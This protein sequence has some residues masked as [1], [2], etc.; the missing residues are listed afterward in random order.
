[1][2]RLCY[3]LLVDVLS[4]AVFFPQSGEAKQRD[5]LDSC[6]DVLS[7]RPDVVVSFDEVVGQ[8]HG[9]CQCNDPEH[10]HFGTLSASIAISPSERDFGDAVVWQSLITGGRPYFVV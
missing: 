10:L 4:R 8:N 9:F 3:T 5:A 6:H 2:V 1:M 7:Y